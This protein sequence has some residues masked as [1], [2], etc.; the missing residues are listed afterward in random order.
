MT[1][2]NESVVEEAAL[3]WLEE[4]GYAR[5]FGPIIAP[6]EAAAERDDYGQ[7][8]MG[9]CFSPAARAPCAG[10]GWQIQ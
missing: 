4:L 7:A 5:R 6:G 3:G 10:R 2:F 1:A 9:D 8:L